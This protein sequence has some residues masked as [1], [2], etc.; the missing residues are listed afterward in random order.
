VGVD[1]VRGLYGVVEAE[2]ATAA[3]LVTTSH[4]TSGAEA[5]AERIPHRLA[6]KDYDELVAWLR[7]LSA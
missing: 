5:F 2:R 4:F 1:L 6:L 7:R 3:L